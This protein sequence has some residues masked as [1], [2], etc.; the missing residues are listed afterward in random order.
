MGFMGKIK[1]MF[2]IGGVKVVCAPATNDISSAGGSVDGRVE[3]TSKTDQHVTK[4]EARMVELWTTGRGQEKK[5]KELEMGK[6][7]VAAD[8]PLKA[9]ESKTL[10]F[11]LPYAVGKSMNDRLKEKGGAIGA[12]G[13]LGAFAAGEK[14]EFELRVSAGVKGTMLSSS[15]KVPMRMA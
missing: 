7:L 8:V 2:G 6:V 10:T 13:K 14:S 5:T 1:Q 11:T 15:A 4:V 12:I 3:L 9:G